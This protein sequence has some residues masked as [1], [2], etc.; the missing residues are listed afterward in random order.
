MNEPESHPVVGPGLHEDQAAP[1]AP[2]QNKVQTERGRIPSRQPF[3]KDGYVRKAFPN[4]GSFPNRTRITSRPLTRPPRPVLPRPEV[5]TNQISSTEEPAPSSTPP[6]V[7]E[8]FLFQDKPGLR[9]D[10]FMKDSSVSHNVSQT[11]EATR[12]PSHHRLSTKIKNIPRLRPSSRR[13]QNGDR[14]NAQ[15]PPYPHGGF[16]RRPSPIRKLNEGTKSPTGQHE[17]ESTAKSRGVLR[18]NPTDLTDPE[19]SSV[20]PQT[21]LS[22]QG[23][24][25]KNVPVQ[26]T[27][28]EGEE[29]RTTVSPVASETQ[30]NKGEN[31]VPKHQQRSM[32]QQTSSDSRLLRPASLPK[33]PYEPRNLSGSQHSQI[34]KYI[35]WNQRGQGPKP[36]R[37]SAPTGKLRGAAF[38]PV[39]RSNGSNPDHVNQT[40]GGHKPIRKSPPG[41]YPKVTRKEAQEEERPTQKEHLKDLEKVDSE[42]QDRQ[43]P[44]GGEES[45]GRTPKDKNRTSES[46]AT[47]DRKTTTGQQKPSFRE[48]P[49][50]APLPVE[51]D[52]PRPRPR[53][54]PEYAVTFLGNGPGLLSRLHKLVISTGTRHRDG[55]VLMVRRCLQQPA[56]ALS[57]IT[58]PLSLL[59]Q[60][61]VF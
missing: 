34:R 17:R 43:R 52:S 23:D 27:E 41:G 42:E 15:G 19:S 58:A 32:V 47:Q 44:A 60:V 24:Q 39:I 26:T 21:T 54:R 56:P 22:P 2:N 57:S 59:H 36:E 11:L 33:R 46:P 8:S 25:L 50:G 37:F 16:V 5:Q 61:Q 55:G 14:L 20:G 30:R 48:P 3:P 51:E 10:T 18:S 45:E 35:S 9:E 31:L 38:K 4:L 29:S 13:A 7:Q 49:P 6:V 28:A 1:A 12:A 40:A 53:P